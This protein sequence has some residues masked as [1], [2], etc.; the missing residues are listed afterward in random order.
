MVGELAQE[1]EDLESRP[2]SVQWDFNPHLPLSRRVSSSPPLPG[3]C[4]YWSWTT[5]AKSTSFMEHIF[6]TIFPWNVCNIF[7]CYLLNNSWSL[8]WN[9]DYCLEMNHLFFLW[10]PFLQLYLCVTDL[11]KPFMASIRYIGFL[12]QFKKV[13]MFAIFITSHL[14]CKLY[15]SLL[16]RDIS[17]RV[18]LACFSRSIIVH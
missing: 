14:K 3:H 4:S 9:Y 10:F 12:I 2:S 15:F 7:G 13:T 16:H 5:G 17:K 8:L 18:P 11:D 1:M 6:K